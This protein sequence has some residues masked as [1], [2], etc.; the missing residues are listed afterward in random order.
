MPA[1]RHLPLLPL[2]ALA[3][4]LPLGPSCQAPAWPEPEAASASTGRVDQDHQAKAAAAF[5]ALLEA[6]QDEER[7]I[8][9]GRRL[10][11]L[12]RYEDAIEVYGRGLELNPDSA[13]LLRHRG[14]RW[15]SLR[16]FE[17]AVEDLARAAELIRDQPDVV[18]QDGLPNARNQPTSSLHTNVWYHLGLARFCRAE[19]DAAT[20]AFG[21]CLAASRNPDMESAARY[22]LYLS[23]L[24]S[25]AP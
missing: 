8:W 5:L 25:S 15:L 3:G 18:E 10:G 9:Y 17:R 12:G 6:P 22:W 14:H 11:Y 4:L 2:L 16:R 7:I 23:T 19:F 13:P 1:P 21:A 20:A 24:R